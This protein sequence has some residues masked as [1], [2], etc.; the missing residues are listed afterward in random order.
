[1]VPPVTVDI[2]LKSQVLSGCLEYTKS[3]VGSGLTFVAP[4]TVS[5]HPSALTTISFGL[6]VPAAA[7]VWVGLAWLEV[8]AS[9]KSQALFCP[10]VLVL[11]KLVALPRH[12]SAAV[13]E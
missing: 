3:T 9:P 11:V 13:N 4:V 6:K 7:Y 10:L 2:S 1:M 12:A 8:P 5:A